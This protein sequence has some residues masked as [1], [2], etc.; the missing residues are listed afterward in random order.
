MENSKVK[1]QANADLVGKAIANGDQN[2]LDKVLD[3]VTTD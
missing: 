1:T 2:T 3:F